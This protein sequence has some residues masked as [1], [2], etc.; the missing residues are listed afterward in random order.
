MSAIVDYLLGADDPETLTQA[1]ELLMQRGSL[2]RL[3]TALTDTLACEA[4]HSR[5]A[6]Y[7]QAIDLAQPLSPELQAVERHLTDC[8]ACMAD[9]AAL[10]RFSHL[11][12][13]QAFSAVPVP[14]SDLAFLNRPVAAHLL[15]LW[16]QVETTHHQL[17]TAI[18]VAL[19]EA[20]AWFTAWPG[21][22]TP[23][24]VPTP[25]LRGEP[26]SGAIQRLILPAAG[27]LSFELTLAPS[28]NRAQI[29][30]GVFESPARQPVSQIPVTLFNQH[31][32]RLHRA[33]TSAAGLVQFD[34][35][36]AGSYH[37]QVRTPSGQW[38]LTVVVN[39]T[40]SE[41]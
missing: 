9:Y 6:E 39:E 30:L 1:V 17:V 12:E 27:G 36:A 20:A 10:Q 32:Q 37:L 13:E 24:A 18:Q 21:D 38:G 16:R 33:D 34:D 31:H 7:A 15:G 40:T 25:V 2:T 14:P 23:Q 26:E 5:L 35:L 41:Q 28:A 8:E 4:C 11:A 3:Q 22:L 29:T 19:N